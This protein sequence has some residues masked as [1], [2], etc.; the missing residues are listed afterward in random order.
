MS[1]HLGQYCV[2]CVYSL[3][4]DYQRREIFHPRGQF[5]VSFAFIS[6]HC[7]CIACIACILPGAFVSNMS[8][9]LWVSILDRGRLMH[10]A[11]GVSFAGVPSPAFDVTCLVRTS[12]KLYG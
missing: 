7:L 9:R 6:L 11:C 10:H 8:A 12:T 1:F 3:V 5:L 2:Q 4:Y